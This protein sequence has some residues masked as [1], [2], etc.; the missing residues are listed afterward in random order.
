MLS[1][2][3]PQ[4][5]LP[6]FSGRGRKIALNAHMHPLEADWARDFPVK[7]LGCRQGFI[8]GESGHDGLPPSQAVGFGSGCPRLS[9]HLRPWQ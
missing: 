7:D 6:I 8:A 3:A 4:L 9:I 2:D 5:L 1:I